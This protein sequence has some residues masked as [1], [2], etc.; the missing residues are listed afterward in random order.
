[1]DEQEQAQVKPKKSRAAQR[2]ILFAS[3]VVWAL[4]LCTFLSESVYQFELLRNFIAQ[5]MIAALGVGIIAALLKSRISVALMAVLVIICFAEM[6]VPL[7]Q[8]FSF[9]APKEQSS[10]K[11]LSYNQNVL[12]ENFDAMEEWLLSDKNNA[13]V[14][15]IVEGTTKTK[16][17]A[18]RI[19][20]VYPHQIAKQTVRPQKKP[21][22]YF[23]FSKYKISGHERILIAE[24]PRQNFVAKFNIKPEGMKNDV[25]IY[26]VH[27][28]SPVTPEYEQ[29]RNAELQ[30]I[31]ELITADQSKNIIAIGDFNNTPYSSHFKEFKER[32]GLHFQSYGLFLN[33]TWPAKF[34]LPFLQIPIDHVFYS[35]N[36]IQQNKMVGPSLFSDHHALIAEFSERE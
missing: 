27:T 32:S 26:A 9:F 13:D 30:K 35:D 16:R 4:Y 29:S 22:S 3:V 24:K 28:Q 15:V 12:N 14:I 7:D 11:I 31:A 36:L 34:N 10:L 8:P 6:R 23:I 17:L 33:P 20:K 2:T 18:N 19:K 25:T 5:I 21:I 1:M